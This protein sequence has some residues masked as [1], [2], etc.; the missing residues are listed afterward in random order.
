MQHIHS[1]IARY[2]RIVIARYHAP[3]SG[4]SRRNTR[5]NPITIASLRKTR[6]TCSACTL[7]SRRG[8]FKGQRHVGA[9]AKLAPWFVL[10][11]DAC[12][13][14]L[15]PNA[16]APDSDDSSKHRH[17]CHVKRQLGLLIRISVL[18][19][20]KKKKKSP[21]QSVTSTGLTMPVRC[22]SP[23]RECDWRSSCHWTIEEVVFLRLLA[24]HYDVCLSVKIPRASCS[25][26]SANRS[27]KSSANKFSEPRATK[28]DDESAKILLRAK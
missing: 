19:P 1:F 22:R 24:H 3:T 11:V 9:H 26:T 4:Q 10:G 6:A 8:E 20:R 15:R 7:C 18:Q 13:T 28:K 23:V 16:Y 2:A 14:R 17:R 27:F 12:T 25:S 5:L 21:V